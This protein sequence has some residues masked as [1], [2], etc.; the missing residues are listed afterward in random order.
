MPDQEK[1]EE[2]ML[3]GQER[4]KLDSSNSHSQAETLKA[5]EENTAPET[6]TPLRTMPL[7]ITPAKE[8]NEVSDA[9]E[10]LGWVA[11]G[12]LEDRFDTDPQYPY[13][14][15]PPELVVAF[16][17]EFVFKRTTLCKLTEAAPIS[18]DRK[19]SIIE[20]SFSYESVNQYKKALMFLHEYQRETRSIVWPSPKKTKK[21][22]DL[23]KEYE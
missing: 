21:I 8:S 20:I 4:P 3:F 12:A 6:E 14:V 9:F 16:F 18:K 5:A 19:S 2:A 10:A 7:E 15:G 17:I 1:D 23:I 22:V 11:I 13:T